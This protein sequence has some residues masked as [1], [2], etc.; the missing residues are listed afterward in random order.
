MSFD[1]HLGNVMIM[2]LNDETK[3]T[4]LQNGET[5]QMQSHAH[6]SC[7]RFEAFSNDCVRMSRM[8]RARNIR[9]FSTRRN[10][11]STIAST[12]LE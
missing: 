4:Y 5:D 10:L 7:N 11:T 9:T 6:I 3:V 1:G 12:K 2:T 8:Y